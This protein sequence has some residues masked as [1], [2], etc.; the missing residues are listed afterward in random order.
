MDQR[1]FLK[2]EPPY[3]AI[4]N[5]DSSSPGCETDMRRCEEEAPVPKVARHNLY[6][7]DD[8]RHNFDDNN[9]NDDN[10]DNCKDG[11]D[12]RDKVNIRRLRELVG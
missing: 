12:D 11:D 8:N 7:N 4:F 1:T 9:D 3:S 10:S 6:Y 5:E 2:Y